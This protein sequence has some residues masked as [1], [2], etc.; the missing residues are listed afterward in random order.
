LVQTIAFD[1]SADGRRDLT[2]Q[3]AKALGISTKE[4]AQINATTVWIYCPASATSPQRTCSGFLKDDGA[5]VVTAG[6]C[7]QD[8]E[9]GNFYDNNSSCIFGNFDPKFLAQ[10][11][12]GLPLGID[13]FG[14]NIR[15]GKAF[16]DSG[17]DYAIIKLS[18]KVPGVKTIPLSDSGSFSLM[19]GEPL[20]MVS[21]AMHGMTNH[22][23]FKPIGQGCA[24]QD[25]DYTHQTPM[26]KGSCL[27]APGASGSFQARRNPKTKK[28]EIVA[29]V[30]GGY[31]DTEE[32]ST[33][34]AGIAV[35]GQFAQDLQGQTTAEAN[36]L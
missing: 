35:D 27:T 34:T 25:F 13:S 3:S 18:K 28:L 24:I 29:M 26:I 9:T 17:G 4:M 5:E 36:G 8:Q 15:I 20:L 11:K 2:P 33:T 7:A 31:D 12:K 23:R 30:K 16:P 19:K 21:G 22:D 32:L 14:A 10:N 6:H 1:P